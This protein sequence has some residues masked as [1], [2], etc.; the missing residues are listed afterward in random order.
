MTSGTARLESRTSFA[1]PNKE[2]RPEGGFCIRKA[3][4]GFDAFVQT[5]AGLGFW[6]IFYAT[7]FALSV[8]MRRE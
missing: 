1:V 6:E 8:F 4:E 5:G 3:S 7:L 2:T